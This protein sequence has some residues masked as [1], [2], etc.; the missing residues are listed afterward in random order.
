MFRWNCFLDI[1]VLTDRKLRQVN[2]L[3]W[4][5]ELN[6][7]NDIKASNKCSCI[8]NNAMNSVPLFISNKNVFEINSSFIVTHNKCITPISKL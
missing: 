7:Y 8:Y 4:S 5:L 3:L 2:K 1:K 6:N